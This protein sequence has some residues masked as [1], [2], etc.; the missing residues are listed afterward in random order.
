MRITNIADL[1][2]FEPEKIIKSYNKKVSDYYILWVTNIFL[3]KDKNK[4]KN[5]KPLPC[6]I[7]Y[8]SRWKDDDTN[9]CLITTEKDIWSEYYRY[10][11]IDKIDEILSNGEAL[12]RGS[13]TYKH[14]FPNLRLFTT[15]K[16]AYKYIDEYRKQYDI[17]KYKEKL[18]R[19]TTDI[20]ILLKEK[21]RLENLI[22][23]YESNN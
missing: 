15:K 7:K 18:S 16:E 10:N 21:E 5:T 20:D 3:D 1:L 22:N 2:G 12:D 8:G 23:N 14:K 6:I 17:K 13:L 4:Y 11:C 19:I 9:F